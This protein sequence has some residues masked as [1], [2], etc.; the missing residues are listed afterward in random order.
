MALCDHDFALLNFQFESG[1][2][3]GGGNLVLPILDV[4]LP[5]VPRTG[6]NRSTKL[7]LAQGTTL[8]RAHAV[9]CEELTI[10][11]KQSDHAT[12]CN[13]LDA[14]TWGAIGRF[15]N[16]N[17]F[18]HRGDVLGAVDIDVSITRQ[19][20]IVGAIRRVRLA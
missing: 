13:N 4:E 5:A 9:E 20:S 16:A 2:A 17:I 8:M 15:G 19:R 3:N 6:N 11:I 10:H 18:T 1:L 12:R 14:L 7:T